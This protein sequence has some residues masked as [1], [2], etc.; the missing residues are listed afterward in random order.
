MDNDCDLSN[1]SWDLTNS[2]CWLNGDKYRVMMGYVFHGIW[3]GR[4]LRFFHEHPGT[5][6]RFLL[7]W[8][9]IEL[10]DVPASQVCFWMFLESIPGLTQM[11]MQPTRIVMI[12][13]L[14]INNQLL[15]ASECFKSVSSQPSCWAPMTVIPSTGNVALERW[16]VHMFIRVHGD[17]HKNMD[18]LWMVYGWFMDGL[19]MV[20]GRFMD[21]LWPASS[22]ENGN[23]TPGWPVT[24]SEAPQKIDVQKKWWKDHSFCSRI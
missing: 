4:S 10:G 14:C 6:W 13:W 24:G 19:L 11:V 3:M 23:P 15:V 21:G 12:L 20:F 9:I 16:N 18:G 5:K 8:E 17:H 22:P 7:L 2:F 1:T